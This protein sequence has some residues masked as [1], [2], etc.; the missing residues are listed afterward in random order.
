MNKLQLKV[1][2]KEFTAKFGLSFLEK[3]TK[4]EGISLQEMFDKFQN[5]TLFFLPKLIF[6]AI[7]N[8]GGKCTLEHIY[9]WLDETGINNA[10]V[11]KFTNAFANSIKV[12]FPEELKDEGKPKATRKK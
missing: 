9:D 3:V 1:G 10:E 8:G 4:T 12:H 11:V 7:E 5:D 2:G 6:Y